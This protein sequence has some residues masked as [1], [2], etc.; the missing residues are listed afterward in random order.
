MIGKN[1]AGETWRILFSQQYEVPNPAR[2]SQYLVSVGLRWLDPGNSMIRYAQKLLS[3]N[4]SP[5]TLEFNHPTSP[6][7]RSAWPRN[8]AMS[9]I[10][11]AV[12]LRIQIC[13]KHTFVI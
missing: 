3:N 8:S 9:A 12:S 13:A 11:S 5:W 7:D 1:N 10:Y 6:R 4:N 2:K